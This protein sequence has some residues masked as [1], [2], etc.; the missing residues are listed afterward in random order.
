MQSKTNALNF[1]HMD[2]PVICAGMENAYENDTSMVW[3]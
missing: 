3:K 2:A 1:A